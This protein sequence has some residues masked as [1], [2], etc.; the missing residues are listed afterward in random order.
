ML[1]IAPDAIIVID[2][3]QNLATFNEG[4]EN[5]FG[6]EAAEVVGKP[7]DLLIPGELRQAHTRHFARSATAP[8][9]AAS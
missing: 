6:Y 5:V 9:S 1:V 4:A 3:D 8:R 2:Q 7:L